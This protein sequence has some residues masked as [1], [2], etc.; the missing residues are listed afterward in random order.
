MARKQTYRS[1]YINQQVEAGNAPEN[2]VRKERIPLDPV[3]QLP[4]LEG[5]VLL[6]DKPLHWTS[7]DIVRKMRNLI[8]IKKLVKSGK[9]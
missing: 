4:Y 6:I 9:K 8:Q 7:F 3:I 1:K 5:K 2:F